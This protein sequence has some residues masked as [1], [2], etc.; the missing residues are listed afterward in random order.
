M[1]RR[2][3]AKATSIVIDVQEQNPGGFAPFTIDIEYYL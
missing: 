3:A 1:P 2:M